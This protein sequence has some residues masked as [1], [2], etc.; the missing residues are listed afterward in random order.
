MLQGVV[1]VTLTID[2]IDMANILSNKGYHLHYHVIGGDILECPREYLLKSYVI[3]NNLDEVFTFHG[4]VSDVIPFYQMLDLMICA[5]HQEAL[6]VCILEAQA[7]GVPVISTNVNGIP[8]MIS[9]NVN[10]F[11]VDAHSPE[12]LSAAVIRLLENPN[13]QQEFTANARTNVEQN[14]SVQSYLNN[15]LKAYQS[16]TNAPANSAYKRYNKL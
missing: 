12:Q 5:S 9:D 10:G 15:F 3:E 14:F 2:F 16:L 7:S 8:E 13:L 6:P 11:L 1:V 4:Q